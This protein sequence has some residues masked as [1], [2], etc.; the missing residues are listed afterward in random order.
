MSLY[1]TYETDTKAEKDGVL[2][3]FGLNSHGQPTM[4][5]ILRAGGANVRFAKVF[6]Q[7]SKPVRR[8]MDAGGLDNATSERIMREVYAEAVVT[9]W[10]GVEDR[11][12]QAIEF[13]KENVAKLF[14]D[15]PD[16]FREV[17]K[18]SQELALF[19]KDLREAEAGN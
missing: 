1:S 8:I 10:E 15:L 18:S 17:V 4:I 11:Q 7:K 14:E 12:G 6:E 5:R 2:L 16:L 13:S 19:R 3:D 9:G